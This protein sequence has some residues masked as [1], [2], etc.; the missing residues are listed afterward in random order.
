MWENPVH[1]DKITLSTS[2]RICQVHAK[3]RGGAIIS[4]RKDTLSNQKSEDNT[5]HYKTTMEQGKESYD[6]IT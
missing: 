5:L 4:K 3:P 2:N 1:T 6:D